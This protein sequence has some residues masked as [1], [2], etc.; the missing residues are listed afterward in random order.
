[1]FI[2]THSPPV[3]P[4]PVLGM[5]FTGSIKKDLKKRI[6]LF[7][8]KEELIDEAAQEAALTN[9]FDRIWRTKSTGIFKMAR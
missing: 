1:M 6:K 9:P 3:A 4:T 5:E 2:L 8:E 7:A